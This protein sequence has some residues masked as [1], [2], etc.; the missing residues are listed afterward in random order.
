[1]SNRRKIKDPP[2]GNPVSEYL[3]SID[4]ARIPGGCDACDAYQV[5]QARAG[6]RD[7]HL[8]KVFHDDDCPVLASKQEGK[9][10]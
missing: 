6:H 4:G 1:M 8:I 5:V 7:V 3:A 10:S 2:P 9:A